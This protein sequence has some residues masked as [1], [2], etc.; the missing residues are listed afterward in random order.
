MIGV[1]VLL[2]A[3]VTLAGCQSPAWKS[4]N[5]PLWA[6]VATGTNE[7]G[8]ARWFINT[9]AIRKDNAE[10]TV[11]VLVRMQTVAQGESTNS[12][13]PKS[14]DQTS[15]QN[16]TCDPKKQGYDI[17][18]TLRSYLGNEAPSEIPPD[19]EL[20]RAVA[21]RQLLEVKR[22]LIMYD[23]REAACFLARF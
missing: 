16:F 11:K 5:P 18:A 12:D 3:T 8:Q 10:R 15:V 13:V 23:V 17:S 14:D 9:R 6:L 22:G 4:D 19:S 21:Y 20:P 7:R 1:L 2:L